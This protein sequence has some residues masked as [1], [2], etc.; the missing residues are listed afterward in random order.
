MTVTL[1]DL[2][3]DRL[4]PW[5]TPATLRGIPALPADRPAPRPAPRPTWATR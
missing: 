2:T 3:L 4:A 1:T 5:L